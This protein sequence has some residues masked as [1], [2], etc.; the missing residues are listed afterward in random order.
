MVTLFLRARSRKKQIQYYYSRFIVPTD[1][2]P[3]LKRREIQ[4]SLRTACYNEARLLGA[5]WGGRV[6]TLFLYLRRN[7]LRMT[8]Q[9]I[10]QLIAQDIGIRLEA[11]EQSC[12]GGGETPDMAYDADGEPSEDQ[13]QEHLAAFC[14]DTIRD[15]A[16]ALKGNE[17]SGAVPLAQEFIKRH[18]LA[19]APASDV[20]TFLCRE[21]LK[22]EQH[23]AKGIKERVQGNYSE[24]YSAP[25]LS[26]S[27]SADLGPITTLIFSEATADYLKH[28]NHLAKGTLRAKKATLGRFRSVMGDRL[29]QSIAKPECIRYRDTIGK[30]PLHMAKRFPGKS[31]AEVLAAV[32]KIPNVPTLSKQTVNQDL[33]HLGHFFAWA[34]NNAHYV[35]DNPVDG[36]SFVGLEGKHSAPFTAADLSRIFGSRAYAEQRAANPARYFLPL[37]LLYTG[38]RREEIAQLAL[39]DIGQEEG[40]WRFDFKPDAVRGT[41]LKN[42]S[43]VRR[44]PI[45]PHLKD[46]GFFAFLK[47]RKAA[48]GVEL[49]PK[50]RGAGKGRATVGD[51]VG[52]WFSRLLIDV[53]IT[54]KKSLHSF[55]ATAI[56]TLH[57]L[58]VD[59]ESRRALM[60]HSGKDV[61]EVV[62]LRLPLS[63]LRTQL[64]KLNFRSVLRN[65]PA[66]K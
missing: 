54:G 60:G 28:F 35:G 20:Y 46:F 18:G 23:I 10:R 2:R 4:K 31:V 55:R 5:Q 66:Y 47:E 3:L 53:G 39:T 14:A 15:S 12:Y 7:G 27:A 25:A 9:Q 58:G 32:S 6:A 30:L 64:E 38:A 1:L 61:H 8:P 50:Q 49:F 63:T 44:V 52:K 16:K 11:W 51:A 42:R 59:A 17:L 40:V 13:W 45:H 57:E 22:A 43:S 37:L 33:T 24:A 19:I 65:L 36:L 62:Y 48:G 41:R 56:S 34:K 29:L 26:P 21:L